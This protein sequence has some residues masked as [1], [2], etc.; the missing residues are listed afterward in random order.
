MEGNAPWGARVAPQDV[1]TFPRRHIRHPHCVVSMSGSHLGPKTKQFFFFI[2]ILLNKKTPKKQPTY[3]TILIYAIYL[4][5]MS[6]S[7]PFLKINIIT[8][9]LFDIFKRKFERTI[10]S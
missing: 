3:Q 2:S 8:E 9:L 5:V 6:I 7:V 1:E 10:S 4:N